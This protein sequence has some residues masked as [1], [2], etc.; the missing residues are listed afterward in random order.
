MNSDSDHPSPIHIG[1]EKPISEFSTDFFIPG[2]A[3]LRLPRVAISDERTRFDLPA[4]FKPDEILPLIYLRGGHLVADMVPWGIRDART[5]YKRYFQECR[6][7]SI[8]YPGLCPA[9]Y[10]ILATDPARYDRNTAIRVQTPE[11]SS[12]NLYVGCFYQPD[13]Q[14]VAR[15][16]VP[17]VCKAGRDL[18]PYMEWQPL[19]VR[20]TPSP[21]QENF[22]FLL[23]RDKGRLQQAFPSWHRLHT[24]LS[25]QPA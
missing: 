8:G 10:L 24:R 25:I 21:V 3:V 13:R 14:G 16:A 5:G 12:W 9:S 7:G 17:M 19:F 22:D 18:S 6:H 15:S 2:K 20:I 23:R 11:G 4:K 1:I